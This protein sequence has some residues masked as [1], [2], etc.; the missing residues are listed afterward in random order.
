MLTTND[1][2]VNATLV[3]FDG[4]EH[5]VEGGEH[6]FVATSSGGNMTVEA[7]V[8][9]PFPAADVPLIRWSVE[10]NPTCEPDAT[11]YAV[12]LR[13]RGTD[14][15]RTFLVAACGSVLQASGEA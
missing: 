2:V 13:Q 10:A 8:P 5:R 15:V 4:F 12:K 1:T 9:E 11:H 3:E 7:R 6:V 14:D